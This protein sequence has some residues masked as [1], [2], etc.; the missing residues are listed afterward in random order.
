MMIYKKIFD[1]REG[2]EKAEL[3]WDLFVDRLSVSLF[4]K[5]L[6]FKNAW[7]YPVKT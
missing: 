1:K 2:K 6:Y 7:T 4:V 3:L 5:T